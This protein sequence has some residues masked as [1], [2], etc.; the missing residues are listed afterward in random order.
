MYGP[1]LISQYYITKL[2]IVAKSKKKNDLRFLIN[3]L[4]RLWFVDI[5]RNL[6]SLAIHFKSPF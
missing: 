4:I 3:H 1:D 6:T 2:N 5:D